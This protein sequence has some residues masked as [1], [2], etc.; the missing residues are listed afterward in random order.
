MSKS[1]DTVAIACSLEAGS[2]EQRVVEWR[3]LVASAV[4]TVETGPTSVRFALQDGDDALL[5]A[6]S[7]GQR[8]KQCCAFF[9][10]SVELGPDTRMLVLH[11]P[12]GAEEALAQFVASLELASS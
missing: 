12:D 6:V 10:V 1:D 4:D 8:E 2:L 7:L 3:D 5:A 9:E 11:V